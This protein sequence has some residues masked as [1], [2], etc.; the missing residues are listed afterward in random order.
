[1]RRFLRTDEFGNRY[2]ALG[3]RRGD[4]NAQLRNDAYATAGLIL[5]I[6][7]AIVLWAGMKH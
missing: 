6:V 1:M 2:E 4:R 5:L 3:E 7:S